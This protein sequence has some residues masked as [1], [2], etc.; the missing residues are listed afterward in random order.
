MAVLDPHHVAPQVPCQPHRHDVFRREL[1]LL[2]EAAAD[3]RRDDPHQRFVDAEAIGDPRAHL[4]RRLHRGVQGDAPG[5]AVERGVAGARLQRHRALTPGF[6]GDLDHG[7]GIGEGL[8]HALAADAGLDQGVVRRLLVHPRR[9]G[10]QRRVDV[11]DRLRGLEVDHHALGRVFRLLR[12]VAERD[13]DRLTGE[14][15]PPLGQDVLLGGDVVGA[16]QQRAHRRDLGEIVDGQGAHVLR[17]RDPGDGGGGEGAAHEAQ[18]GGAGGEVAD[19]AAEAA[20][21]RSVLAPLEP[22]ADPAH[23]P[24]ARSSARRVIVRARSRR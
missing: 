9:A 14:A 4:V 6:D 11:D 10:R 15:H 1:H 8:R 12:R 17:D 19:I 16:E 24:Q 20:N 22:L 2:A 3:I 23:R 21:E 5:A 13:G 7:G 18:E